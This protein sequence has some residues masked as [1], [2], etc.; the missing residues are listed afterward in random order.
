MKVPDKFASLIERQIE[1]FEDK[2]DE[3][4]SLRKQASLVDLYWL[5]FIGP[6]LLHSLG[7]AYLHS[8]RLCM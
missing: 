1:I 2:P 6:S 4:D 3:Q 8:Y 5:T 7:E